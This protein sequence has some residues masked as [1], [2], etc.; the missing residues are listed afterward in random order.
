MGGKF[1]LAIASPSIRVKILEI[2]QELRTSLDRISACSLLKM[3]TWVDMS[4]QWMSTYS[5]CRHI[6]CRVQALSAVTIL[7]ISS[8]I[9]LINR[10]IIALIWSLKLV[11]SMIIL[12]YLILLCIE[13]LLFSYHKCWE[14]SNHFKEISLV[15]KFIS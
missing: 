4:T 11:Y 12:W 3:S 13:W 5:G 10:E 7:S 6:Q 1:L 9:F 2:R 15:T 14:K 8:I